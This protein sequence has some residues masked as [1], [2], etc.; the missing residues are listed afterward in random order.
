MDQEN[1]SL[2]Q[3]ER[4]RELLAKYGTLL[5]AILMFCI[6]GM[7]AKHFFD[8]ENIM[9]I[10]KQISITAIISIGMTMVILIGGIDLSVGSVVLLSGVVTYGMLVD[11]KFPLALAIPAGLAAAMLVGLLNGFFIEKVKIAPVI[12]TL[13]TMMT[14]KGLSQILLKAYNQW[15][16]VKNGPLSS[17]AQGKLGIIPVIILIVIALYVLAFV[18][19]N[20]TRFGKYIYAV[21]GNSLAAKY[22]GINVVR[23]KITVYVLCSLF[24]GVSGIL[25]GGRM[26]CINS[27]FGMGMEFDAITAVILGGTSLKGGAGRIEKSFIGAAIVG[28]ILNYLTLG[29][30]SA[31]Y[32]SI[33]TGAVILIA[34][35]LDRATHGKKQ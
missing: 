8:A 11:D 30:I 33:V 4:S 20:Y 25:L 35:L 14:V 15:I 12:V 1:K 23:T 17:I 10:L 27:S 9:N 19:M 31:N 16:W 7:L 24:A 13:G 22:V 21:G 32:Q 29:G 26:G 6:F 2:N 3:K 5:L 18:I 28:L 34:A